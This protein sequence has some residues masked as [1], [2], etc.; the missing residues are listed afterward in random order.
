MKLIIAL[1]ADIEKVVMGSINNIIHAVD[2]IVDVELYSIGQIA[3][4]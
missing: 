1:S 4:T 2:E 3:E